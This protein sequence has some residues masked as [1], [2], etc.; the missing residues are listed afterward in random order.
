M[1][2]LDAVNLREV[3]LNTNGELVDVVFLGVFLAEDLFEE[4]LEVFKARDEPRRRS[5]GRR[6]AVNA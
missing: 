5:D 1:Q 4:T 6:L 2:L 3:F